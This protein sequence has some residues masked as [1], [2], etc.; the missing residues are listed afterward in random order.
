MKYYFLALRG[1]KCSE[2]DFLDIPMLSF[3]I[4]IIKKLRQIQSIYISRTYMEVQ[5]R[6]RWGLQVSFQAQKTSIECSQCSS[7]T[8]RVPTLISLQHIRNIEVNLIKS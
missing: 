4:T 6:A 3:E 5:S 7:N 8:S 2:A 1:L